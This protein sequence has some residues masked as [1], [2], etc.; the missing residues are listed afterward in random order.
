MFNAKSASFNH[1]ASRP[2][3]SFVS[4]PIDFRLLRTRDTNQVSTSFHAPSRRLLSV[5]DTAS[6]IEYSDVHISKKRFL[7]FLNSEE[8]FSSAF[9]II[10]INGIRRETLVV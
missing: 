9:G 7:W 8:Y 10:E 2:D 5:M 4:D 1:F 6:V 3:G